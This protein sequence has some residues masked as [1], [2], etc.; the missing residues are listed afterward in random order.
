MILILFTNHYPFKTGEQFLHEEL[1]IAEQ[2]F[3]EIRLVSMETQIQKDVELL[4][5]NTSLYLPRKRMNN[6]LRVIALLHVF[7]KKRFWKEVW[8]AKHT[9]NHSLIDIIKRILIDESEIGYLKQHEKEWLEGIDD[10]NNT[11]FYSYWLDGAATYLSRSCYK[12]SLK[13]SRCHGGDCFFDRGYHPYRREQLAGLDKI[14][15]ISE[16]GRQDI[17]DHYRCDVS[18]VNDKISVARLGVFTNEDADNPW[19]KKE[20]RIIVTCSNIIRLKRLDLIIDALEDID[21][22][23]I[24]WIHF[25]DGK[26]ASVIK[27]YAQ[28]KLDKK[29]NI[30]YVFTGYKEKTYI[31]HFYASQTV[32][33]FINCSDVE[34]IPV[35]MMEAMSYGIPCIGRSVG[36]INELLNNECGLL[37]EQDITAKELANSIKKI[38]EMNESEYLLKRETSKRTILERYNAENNY[39]LFFEMI[40][41]VQ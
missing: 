17:I 26:E 21:E 4:S 13:I 37:L 10:S 34:G 35:S 36:G 31:L 8:Y 16:A 29:K 18:N 41:K 40:K 19:T 7:V 23:I 38:L 9:T 1:S 3:N 27:Q 2:C 30:E 22:L 5:E 32:D 33:L 39:R 28:K 12:N 14:Y 11:V 20:K 24:Q 25:G 6:M 15:T